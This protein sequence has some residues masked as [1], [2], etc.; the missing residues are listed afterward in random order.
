LPKLTTATSS[1]TLR[2]IRSHALN[3]MQPLHKARPQCHDAGLVIPEI[4]LSADLV[5]LAC[6]L[7]D[8]RL[9]VK[10]GDVQNIPAA[11]R[12]QMAE[13][14]EK[15]IKEHESIWLKCNRIGGLS[16]SSAAMAELLEMLESK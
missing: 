13:R 5:L 4:H 9:A 8:A 16:D 3:A 11:Q 7:L 1:G 6:D 12:K 14:L 2:P 10:D 15:L